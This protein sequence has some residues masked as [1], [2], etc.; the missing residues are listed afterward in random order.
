MDIFH[1]LKNERLHD[2]KQWWIEGAGGGGLLCKY[3]CDEK[4]N[5]SKGVVTKK[6]KKKHW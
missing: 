3:F 1:G 4:V 2:F 6:K 5:A